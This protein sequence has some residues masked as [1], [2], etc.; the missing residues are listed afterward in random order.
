MTA[1][2]RSIL[3]MKTRIVLVG[4]LSLYL[5]RRRVGW[6]VRTPFS[7]LVGDDII[8][9]RLG[10]IGVSGGVSLVMEGL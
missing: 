6:R 7:L 8:G 4:S 10:L 1:T 9:I 3:V 2:W 5:L